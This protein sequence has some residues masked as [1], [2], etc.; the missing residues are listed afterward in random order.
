MMNK[1]IFLKIFSNLFSWTTLHRKPSKNEN[2]K[3]ITYWASLDSEKEE[4]FLKL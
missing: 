3:L 1:V 4:K 2:N